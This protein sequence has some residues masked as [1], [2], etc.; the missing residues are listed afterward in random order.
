M[1]LPRQIKQYSSNAQYYLQA[2][3][4]FPSPTKDAVQ[5]LLLI[6]GWEN[7]ILAE[8]ELLSSQLDR[9]IN[10]KLKKDHAVKLDKVD[11]NSFVERIIVSPKGKKI[12]AESIKYK[13]GQELKKLREICQYGLDNETFEV[14]ELFRRHWFTDSLRNGLIQKIKWVNSWV[15]YIESIEETSWG[16]DFK[17]KDT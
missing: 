5:I 1:K 15:N 16:W 6:T 13:T 14:A 4:K 11:K 2:A 12:P 3:D 10:P 17:T 7:I 9:L 8:E